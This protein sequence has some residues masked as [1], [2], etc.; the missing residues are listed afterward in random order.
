[1]RSIRSL[2]LKRPSGKKEY[3]EVYDWRLLEIIK[4]SD[5]GKKLGY[6]VWKRCWIGGA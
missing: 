4:K 6:D 5:K 3:V 2:D 1:M